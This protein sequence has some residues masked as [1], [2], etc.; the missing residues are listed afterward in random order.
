M[1]PVPQ[2]ACERAG[3]ILAAE[4]I[5]SQLQL[6]VIMLSDGSLMLPRTLLARNSPGNRE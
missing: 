6:P 1:L 4:Y 2:P 3:M 5:P